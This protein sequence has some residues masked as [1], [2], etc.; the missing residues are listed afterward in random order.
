MKALGLLLPV[1]LVALAL[2]LA[3][4]SGVL[5]RLAEADTGWLAAAVLLVAAQTLLQAWRWR[6]V[7]GALGL[8]IAPGR[9]IGEVWLAQLVNQV[10][11]GGIV[12]DASRAFRSREAGLGRAARIVILER[13]T[14]Q[15]GLAAIALPGLAVFVTTGSMPRV[16]AAIGLA[17]LALLAAVVTGF[18]L[19]AQTR[20]VAAL[21]RD[22]RALW[23]NAAVIVTLC[24]MAAGLNLA[25]FAAAA[26]ATG[27]SLPLIAVVG[28][29]PLILSAMLLP[30]TVAG[31]GWREGAAAA[32]F[33]AMGLA[34]EAGLAASLAFGLAVLVAALPG[35][36]G[37]LFA[38]H[39]PSLERLP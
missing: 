8:P 18:A 5:A 11:P 6:V 29:V 28:L 1:A 13:A 7:A 12:G 17:L 39:Q 24:L 33:P 25:A 20:P 9:A 15:A 14:G 19:G 4:G 23:P 27:T 10:V 36:A 37:L 3:G 2:W 30:A 22:A 34:A 16:A 31:W 38:P 32:L 26:R 35:A 21:F